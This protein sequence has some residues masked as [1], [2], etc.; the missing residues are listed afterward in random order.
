MAFGKESIADVQ[1]ESSHSVSLNSIADGADLPCCNCSSICFPLVTL[2]STGYLAKSS[3]IKY[4]TV[5]WIQIVSWQCVC[6][7][8]LRALADIVMGPSLDN[9]CRVRLIRALETYYG[10]HLTISPMKSVPTLTGMASRQQLFAR[11]TDLSLSLE[12]WEQTGVL[13]M[14]A[15]FDYLREAGVFQRVDLILSKTRPEERV[16]I[17][18]KCYD[19]LCETVKQDPAY[20]ALVVACREDQNWRLL[21]RPEITAPHG[22]IMKL[23]D[24]T[25]SVANHQLQQM[26]EE[27]EKGDIQSTVIFPSAVNTSKLKILPCSGENWKTWIKSSHPSE[28][29]PNQWS[30]SWNENMASCFGDPLEISAHVGDLV[31]TQPHTLRWPYTFASNNVINISQS[32]L[33]NNCE[34]LENG[35]EGWWA[36]LAIS[37]N[38][39]RYGEICF[40]MRHGT[41]NYHIRD[42]IHDELRIGAKSAL[43]EALTG[44]RKWTDKKVISE[45]NLV[46]GLDDIPAAAF[47]RRVRTDLLLELN[48]VLNML[49]NPTQGQF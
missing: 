37:K 38:S 20:Y 39:P 3:I 35:L 22:S 27:N 45:C 25:F 36:Q 33:D 31:I 1:T 10:C 40:G 28:L 2:I 14:P 34:T 7:F 43:G 44:L 18:H 48:Q 17:T 4:R 5:R 6:D 9:P 11:L 19:L 26:V 29:S 46:L 24:V 13:Y 16:V 32:R 42:H 12:M 49:E 15:F 8:H 47:I 21:H 30:W 23:D 41:L